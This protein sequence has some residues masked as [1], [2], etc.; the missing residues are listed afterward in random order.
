[1]TPCRNTRLRPW[2]ATEH[3]PRILR[4]CAEMAATGIFITTFLALPSALAAKPDIEAFLRGYHAARNLNYQDAEDAVDVALRADPDS[5]E[6]RNVAL[7]TY[8][9]TGRIE[10]SFT[11]ARELH[12]AGETNPTL[13]VILLADDFINNG[14]GMILA[15]SMDADALPLVLYRLAR[16][17]SLL[18]DGQ[19]EE[20]LASFTDDEDPDDIAV[21]M[22]FHRMLANALTGNTGIALE[23]A[24]AVEIWPELIA[25]DSRYVKAQL[26][27]SIGDHEGALALLGGRP[28][29]EDDGRII[30][31][32]ALHDQLGTDE[33]I[34]FDYIGSADEGLAEGFVILA[35][36]LAASLRHDEAL[37]YLQLARVMDPDNALI[38]L[39]LATILYDTE[40]PIL[41]KRTLADSP[42]EGLFA[43]K[44][45]LIKARAQFKSGETD[46]AFSTLMDAIEAHPQSY[47]LPNTLGDLYRQEEIYRDAI[48]AY[49][50]ALERMEANESVSKGWLINFHRAVTY[51]EL[52][53][54]NAAEA[55]FRTALDIAG[56]TPFLLNY[57]GYSLADRNIKL[58]E[59]EALI[60]D[61]VTA[62]PNNGM[63]V[64][65]LGWVL[66]RQGRYEEALEQ[67]EL[68]VRLMSPDPVVIDHL[69][70]A[71]WKTGRQDYAHEQWEI[72]LELA[73]D[74]KLIKRIQRKLAVG[75]DRVLEE[76]AAG[77]ET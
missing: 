7:H 3:L 15:E 27:A 69:G 11:L 65:S 70:D 10:E 58:D 75:L 5:A 76:E 8:L 53:E 36:I 50:L 37:Q 35:R 74:E 60:R 41:A 57:L 23:V 71:Y 42:R 4:R 29:S 56:Q 26:L 30:R 33:A 2:P 38:T 64:D 32:M 14:S 19:I 12:A 22:A 44:S 20:A 16:A 55:D 49:D 63:Y 61:A 31:L 51:M 67:L 13:S 73:K 21:I 1:M 39:D 6:V 40:N 68:A 66:Y 45:T 48:E 47:M 34:V 9:A 43:S 54:W 24:D 52:D 28:Y 25:D 46:T 17:W 18:R 72:A 77:N 62:E 59:A